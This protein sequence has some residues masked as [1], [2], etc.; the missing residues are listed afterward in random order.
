MDAD[1]GEFAPCLF[2][3]YEGLTVETYVAHRKTRHQEL[4]GATFD[5]TVARKSIAR[6]IGDFDKNPA[7]SRRLTESLQTQ[8]GSDAIAR[9]NTGKWRFAKLPPIR[10]WTFACDPSRYD[11]LAACRALNT[12]CWAVKRSNPQIGDKA[13]IWQGKDDQGLRG[14]VGFGEIIEGP[15]VFDENPDEEAFYK[16]EPP[17]PERRIRILL[18]HASGLPLWLSDQDDLLSKLN[19]ARAY[20]GTV[21]QL[22]PDQWSEIV[23]RAEAISQSVAASESAGQGWSTDP[24]RRRAIETYAQN[25]AARYFRDRGYLVADVSSHQPYDLNC[26]NENEEL[27]VEVKGCSGLGTSVFLTRNEVEHAR[28]NAGNAVLFIVRGIKLDETSGEIE[29]SGGRP[30]IYR[31]WAVDD[32]TLLPLSYQYA[33]PGA[34][35]PNHSG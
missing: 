26:S 7:L 32:G 10:H 13:V 20:G 24:R 19:V 23:D 21:F 29:A 16:E 31:P 15:A 11:V 27:H 8:L 33:P 4:E 14:V 34:D 12:I 17:G 3:A 9:L 6:I 25:T 22:T 5:G 2:L 28:R 18:R 1:R 30:E 35:G